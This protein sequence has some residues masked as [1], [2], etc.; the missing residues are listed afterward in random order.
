M[1]AVVVAGVGVSRAL[2]LHGAGEL[3]QVFA[4]GG[5]LPEDTMLWSI[6]QDHVD[7]NLFF[8]GGEFGEIPLAFE[9]LS[10][11]AISG[12][13]LSKYMKIAYVD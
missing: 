3:Q 13:G 11:S 10:D 4:L 6:V 5:D 7:A 2:R 9:V 12:A 1:E 8:L